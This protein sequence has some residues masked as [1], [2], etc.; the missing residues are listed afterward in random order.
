M[1]AG[2]EEKDKI[3]GFPVYDSTIMAFVKSA[4]LGDL[5]DKNYPYIYTRNHIKSRED[6]KRLIRGADIDSF[7]ILK[8][9]L[10]KYVLEGMRKG[11]VWSVAVNEG[12]F[13]SI[14]LKMKEILD[15]WDKHDSMLT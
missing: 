9:I 5:M 13:L 3:F 15:F 4:S 7:D 12:I 1:Y 8:G 6:E 14:L 11:T 2:N 10:S